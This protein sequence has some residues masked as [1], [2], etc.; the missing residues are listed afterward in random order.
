MDILGRTIPSVSLYFVNLV[1]VKIFS[2][3][4]LEVSFIFCPLFFLS[5]FYFLFF[6][7]LFFEKFDKIHLYYDLSS[8]CSHFIHNR[9]LGSF[10]FTI[11]FSSP[12]I[13]PFVSSFIPLSSPILTPDCN[14][15]SLSFR[16]SPSQFI[17][18]LFYY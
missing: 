2:A 6:I 11:L 17:T 7:F 13:S 9:V 16:P 18:P 12:P 3:V 4:P 5:L 15:I 8:H 14:F 10:S 1:I